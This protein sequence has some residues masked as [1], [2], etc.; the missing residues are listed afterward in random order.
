MGKSRLPLHEALRPGC[1]P[2]QAG[3]VGQSLFCLADWIEKNRPDQQIC[4]PVTSQSLA[5]MIKIIRPPVSGF[6]HLP[7]I[8]QLLRQAR[9]A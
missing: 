3:E 2:D 4:Q 1:H 5:D 6:N 8:K 9:S 7:A